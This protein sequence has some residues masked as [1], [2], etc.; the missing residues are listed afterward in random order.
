MEFLPDGHIRLTCQQ[1]PGYVTV[2]RPPQAEVLGRLRTEAEVAAYAR[3]RG[4]VYDHA[5]IEESPAGLA[6]PDTSPVRGQPAQIN[7]QR[8]NRTDVHDPRQWAVMPD[9]RYRSP[10]GRSYG[11]DTQLGR[12]IADWRRRAGLDQ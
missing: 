3:W 2:C 9:G 1:A 12:R 6:D 5:A 11:P 7:R 4:H 8:Q 10:R